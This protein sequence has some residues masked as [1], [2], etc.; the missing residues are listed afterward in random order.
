MDATPITTLPDDPAML[1][2]L[3]M[4]ERAARAADIE[5]IK[6]EAARDREIIKEEATNQIETMKQKTK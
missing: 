5:Q 4:Q 2:E 1:K 3:L 6:R